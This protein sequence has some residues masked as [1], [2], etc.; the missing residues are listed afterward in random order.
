[1]FQRL[2]A[3]FAVAVN[4]SVKGIRNQLIDSLRGL[5]LFF[6]EILRSAIGT[7][8]CYAWLLD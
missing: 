1:M 3:E 8:L 4:A 7:R 5:D 2:V 6:I